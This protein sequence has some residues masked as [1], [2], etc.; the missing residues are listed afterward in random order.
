[1]D[2]AIQS[3]QGM[4]GQ[5]GLLTIG[6]MGEGSLGWKGTIIDGILERIKGHA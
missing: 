2:E 5:Q 6:V 4:V 3:S 1:M